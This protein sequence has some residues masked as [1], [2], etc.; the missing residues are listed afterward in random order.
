MDEKLKVQSPWI[1]NLGSI[2]DAM[3]KQ[4]GKQERILALQGDLK[5]LGSEKFN[6]TLMPEPY[7]GNPDAEI[8][9]LN[10]NP[11]LDKLLE[12]ED[13]EEIKCL[14]RRFEEHILCNY[15]FY[16]EVGG[17]SCEKYKEFPFYHLNPDYKCFQGFWWWYGKL[18]PL[19]EKVSEKPGFSKLEEAFKKVASSIFGIELL[20]YHSKNF[21]SG[22]DL[23][24]R[25]GEGN[26]DRPCLESVKYNI[27]LVEDALR[28]N[29]TIIIMKGRVEWVEL[30]KR[31]PDYKKAENRVYELISTQNSVITENNI[32]PSFNRDDPKKSIMAELADI[33]AT[34]K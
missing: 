4:R 6:Y 20:P 15:A 21:G 25:L 12:S 24:K 13:P 27:R 7:I 1:I 32:N 29:K 14:K 23:V 26:N 8:Y 18:R 11:A 2:R 16:D 31:M 19:I 28:K 34:K 22:R 3:D 17:I 30:I 10:L 9:L 5:E 33:I